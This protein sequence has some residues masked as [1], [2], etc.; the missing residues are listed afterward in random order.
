[1]L[2]PPTAICAVGGFGSDSWNVILAQ[3]FKSIQ[4]TYKMK[5]KMTIEKMDVI[6]Y[7]QCLTQ[8]IDNSVCPIALFDKLKNKSIEEL[9]TIQEELIPLYNETFKTD[10]K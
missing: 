9:R 6:C 3:I 8:K 4:K 1:M 5:H 7:I 10:K 2:L